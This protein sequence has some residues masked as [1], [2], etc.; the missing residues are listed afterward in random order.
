MSEFSAALQ[1]YF[2]KFEAS[3]LVLLIMLGLGIMMVTMPKLTKLLFPFGTQ[4][5]LRTLFSWV[6]LIFVS[7]FIAATLFYRIG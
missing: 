2:V 4:G 1:S 6:F 7:L 3:D 5:Q